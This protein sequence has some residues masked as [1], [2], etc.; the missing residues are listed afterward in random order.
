MQ[1]CLPC[2]GNAKHQASTSRRKSWSKRI[3]A[4][5]NRKNT[6][7]RLELMKYNPNLSESKLHDSGLAKAWLCMGHW[8]QH[9][10]ADGCVRTTCTPSAH[11]RHAHA[12]KELPI[13]V[14]DRKEPFPC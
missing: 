7:E 1:L 2:M 11:D 12:S 4:P 10:W 9:W 14:P 3:C 5:Q 8:Q 13:V 6:P